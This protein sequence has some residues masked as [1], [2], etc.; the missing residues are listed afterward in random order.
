MIFAFKAA[1]EQGLMGGLRT[2]MLRIAFNAHAHLFL[3]RCSFA[4]KPFSSLSFLRS[5]KGGGQG[6]RLKLFI[7]LLVLYWLE[8]WN[9]V[10]HACCNL[11]AHLCA[12]TVGAQW[13][14]HESSL[15]FPS[16]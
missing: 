11:I 16:I 1:Q 15:H 10:V 12:K 8:A 14:K 9:R 5:W 7:C 6:D 3:K 13:V 2:C 4:S